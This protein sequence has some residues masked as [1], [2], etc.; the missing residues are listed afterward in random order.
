MTTQSLQCTH[1]AFSVNQS[2][3]SLIS[4]KPQTSEL[5]SFLHAWAACTRLFPQ[6]HLINPSRLLGEVNDSTNWLFSK[7]RPTDLTFKRDKPLKQYLQLDP[8]EFI[9]S[10]P[11]KPLI[12]INNICNEHEFLDTGLRA[13]W[14]WILILA[15]SFSSWIYLTFLSL[16]FH[17]L[18]N[19]NHQK[20]GDKFSGMLWD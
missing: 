6:I 3:S 2:V 18:K 7:A 16:V 1:S 13:R 14:I 12:F 11:N 19:D 4:L 9:Y 17:H 8:N 15:L 5:L 10:Y 20:N